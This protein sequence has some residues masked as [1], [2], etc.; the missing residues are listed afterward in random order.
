MQADVVRIMQ[1]AEMKLVRL[2]EAIPADK[3]SWKPNKD[4]RSMS[5][6]FLHV[7]AGNFLLP[8]R[9]G[10]P[11]PADFKREG[12]EKS[13][14][15]KAKVIESLKQSFAHAKQAVTKLTDA[16]LTK[17]LQWFDGKPV[18]YRYAATFLAAHEHE[19]L[20]QS[21]AYARSMGITPPWTEEQQQKAQQ[22]KPKTSG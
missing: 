4:V 20:G 3:Y 17:T 7:A 2:A 22:A 9:I 14:T 1:D 5:E 10:T 15:D 8:S 16:D 12:F 18:T 19:H 13:T 21:I 11:A 6:V